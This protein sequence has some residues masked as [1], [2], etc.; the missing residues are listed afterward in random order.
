MADTI[1][2]VVENKGEGHVLQFSPTERLVWKAT[3]ATTGGVMDQFELIAEPGHA[4]APEHVHHTVDE[5]FYI[6]EG[7]FLFKVE[8]K[9]ITVGVGSFLFVPRE[10]R[11]TWRNGAAVQSRMLL[12]YI[13]GGM[14]PFFEECSPYMYA[15]PVDMVGLEKVNQKYHT[16]IVGPPLQP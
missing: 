3:A 8:D 10:T 14:E 11:H 7:T 9:L 1:Q 12:T 16:D 4:G 5:F 2:P 15:D 6:L 13:P